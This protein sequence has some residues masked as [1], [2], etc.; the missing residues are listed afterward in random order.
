MIDLWL[1]LQVKQTNYHFSYS[2]Q[3]IYLKT[4]H[5]K[6]FLINSVVSSCF[7][8]GCVLEVPMT[9]H[10][11]DTFDTVMP[12][13]QHL[14]EL[15]SS[16]T[17][18][19]S[20]LSVFQQVSDLVQSK[21]SGS[22]WGLPL[23]SSS[24]WILFLVALKNWRKSEEKAIKSNELPVTSSL[25]NA[26]R[27]QDVSAT[28][29]LHVGIGGAF[30]EEAPEHVRIAERWD[31]FRP[32]SYAFLLCFPPMPSCYAFLLWVLWHSFFGLLGF[33]LFEPK[34]LG[35]PVTNRILQFQSL[36]HDLVFQCQG[37]TVWQCSL[38]FFIQS[39]HLKIGNPSGWFDQNPSGTPTG[40]SSNVS[41]AGTPNLFAKCQG[42]SWGFWCS[43]RNSISSQPYI[44]HETLQTK[45]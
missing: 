14:V 2:V 24:S 25:P 10:R 19:N 26:Q 45:H 44:N 21:T 36:Q 17:K 20:G 33:L 7:I 18:L 15:P 16:A 30:P 31:S 22:S 39:D 11:F 40:H 37:P 9:T 3:L 28:T 43:R 35:L 42:S 12:N 27:L 4:V 38:G 6:L 8:L 5:S 13:F 41:T 23:G 32:S 29:D 1:I 34:N